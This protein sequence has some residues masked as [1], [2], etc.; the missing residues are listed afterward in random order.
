[1]A[2]IETWRLQAG[3]DGGRLNQPVVAEQIGIHERAYR[4]AKAGKPKAK[5]HYSKLTRFAEK[6][7]LLPGP[8]IGRK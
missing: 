5:D 7:G 8:K 1:M 6:K 2:L 3:E 4:A